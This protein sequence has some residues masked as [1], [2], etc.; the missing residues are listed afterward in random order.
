MMIILIWQDEIKVDFTLHNMSNRF[1][2]FMSHSELA[3][4]EDCLTA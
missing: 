2:S 1:S 4:A 3:E